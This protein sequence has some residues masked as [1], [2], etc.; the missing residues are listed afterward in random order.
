MRRFCIILAILSII[1]AIAFGYV[2][3]LKQYALSFSLKVKNYYID[4]KENFTLLINDYVNQATQIKDMRAK[5]KQLEADSIKHKALQ[6]EFDN[7]YYALDSERHYVDPDVKLVK[8]I[9]YVTLGTYTKIWLNYA[10]VGDEPKIFGLV[11]DG[12]AIGIAKMVDNHLLGILNGDEDCSYSVYIGENRVPG[13]L[14]TMSNGNMVIDYIPAWQ[15]IKSGDNVA[16]SGLD[17]IFFEDVQVG[18]I[19]NIKP[20]SGYLRAELKPYKFSNR[21]DYVW[22]I[23]TKIPQITNL[24][25]NASKQDDNN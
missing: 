1:L 11:K 17:G 5:I 24:N 20:E 8:V 10:Y 15:S 16:T 6:I 7:L 14:R 19:G 12:Y 21:L 4:T 9:S 25:I 18:T 22:I 13:I 3:F 23:D 2:P